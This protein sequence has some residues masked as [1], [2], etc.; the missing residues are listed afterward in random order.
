MLNPL[1]VVTLF[2]QVP[3]QVGDCVT[4]LFFSIFSFILSMKVSLLFL[5]THFY[6]SC[7]WLQKSCMKLPLTEGLVAQ[8]LPRADNSHILFF[9]QDCSLL[10]MRPELGRPENL[11]VTRLLV[12]PVCIRP[13]VVSDLQSGTL[14]PLLFNSL[15]PNDCLKLLTCNYEKLNLLSVPFE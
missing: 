15:S 14:V 13:S 12:P 3:D 4:F 5:K 9:E 6:N 8:V 7:F 1:R 2:E 11:I 10:L